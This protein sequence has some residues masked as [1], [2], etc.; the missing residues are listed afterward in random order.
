MLKS[1][2]MVVICTLAGLA[3][4]AAGAGHD[5]LGCGDCHVAHTPAEASGSG[6]L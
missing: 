1:L 3:G 5:K 6:A 4:I 2:R